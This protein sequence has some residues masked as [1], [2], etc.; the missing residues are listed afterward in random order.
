MREGRGDAKQRDLLHGDDGGLGRKR[1]RMSGIGQPLSLEKQGFDD[2]EQARADDA[3][4]QE[5]G[6]CGGQGRVGEGG[7]RGRAE[8]E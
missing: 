6:G 7:G 2:D 3:W 4:R 1:I 8:K 5:R